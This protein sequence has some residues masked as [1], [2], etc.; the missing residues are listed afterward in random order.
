MQLDPCTCQ[1][2]RPKRIKVHAHQIHAIAQLWKHDSC[3]LFL[4]G[5]SHHEHIPATGDARQET[6]APR[7]LES[8]SRRCQ[9]SRHATCHPIQRR[10]SKPVSASVAGPTVLEGVAARVECTEAIFDK[11]DSLITVVFFAQFLLL[12]AFIMVGAID[13]QNRADPS[14]YAHLQSCRLHNIC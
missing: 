10:T 7:F 6:S 5:C 2:H 4:N 12:V 14:Q 13:G 8:D 9:C 3:C 1:W 11:R